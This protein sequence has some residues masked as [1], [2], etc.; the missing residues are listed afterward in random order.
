MAIRAVTGLGAGDTIRE[1]GT[2]SGPAVDFLA[3]A[4]LFLV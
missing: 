3:T 2:V 4:T 1:A